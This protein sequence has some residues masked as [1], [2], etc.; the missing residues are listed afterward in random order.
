MPRAPRAKAAA[1]PPVPAQGYRVRNFAAGVSAWLDRLAASRSDGARE[2]FAADITAWRTSLLEELQRRGAG[3]ASLPFEQ[4]RQFA[5]MLIWTDEPWLSVIPKA[6]AAF[7]AEL[8]RVCKGS[9]IPGFTGLR[10]VR[11]LARDGQLW[12]ASRR[13]GGIRI[14]IADLYLLD[15]SGEV[16]RRLAAFL[17]GRSRNVSRERLALRECLGSEMVRLYLESIDR[18]MECLCAYDSAWSESAAGLCPARSAEG[19]RG[20]ESPSFASA[21]AR[22]RFYDLAAIYSA[23]NK[24]YFSNELCM[25]EL[26]WS[27]RMAYRRVGYY[28]PLTNSIT[29]S[30]ALDAADI[31]E[32]V[33]AYVLYHEMLHQAARFALL[34]NPGRVHGAAFRAE[35]RRFPRSSEAARFLKKLSK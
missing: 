19:T 16:P 25:P 11:Y 8:T 1:K 23:N 29:L 10:Q 21:T 30:R 24:E 13:M 3:I 22:G 9:I 35:E 31:P 6:A 4:R 26:S 14:A 32:Y 5:R 34:A 7:E 2:L 20:H 28:D 12:E 18:A 17:C 27:Q 33:V 15:E